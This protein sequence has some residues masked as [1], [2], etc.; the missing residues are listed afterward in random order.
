MHF[1]V[2][3]LYFHP[4]FL[5]LLYLKLLKSVMLPEIKAYSLFPLF[6]ILFQEIKTIKSYKVLFQIYLNLHLEMEIL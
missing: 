2:R 6:K 5:N 1:K 3:L 4:E